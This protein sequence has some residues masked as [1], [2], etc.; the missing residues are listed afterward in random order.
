MIIV[1]I[2]LKT[3]TLKYYYNPT[4]LTKDEKN[5]SIPSGTTDGTSIN[6][7]DTSDVPRSNR[8]EISLWSHRG[9]KPRARQTKS[10]SIQKER[11]THEY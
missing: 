9:A 10:Q 6:R 3:S 2:C 7:D 8:T 1:N 4:E 5:Q 11:L